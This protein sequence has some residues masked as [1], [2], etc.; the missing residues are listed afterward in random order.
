MSNRIA[1]QLPGG[2]K[3]L[4]GDDLLTNKDHAYE[5]LAAVLYAVGELTRAYLDEPI[6]QTARSDSTSQCSDR[7]ASL[8]FLRL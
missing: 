7:N 3:A 4:R 6:R 1:C 2:E 5:G 8:S